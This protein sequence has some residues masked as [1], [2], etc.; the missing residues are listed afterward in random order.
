MEKYQRGVEGVVGAALVARELKTDQQMG[1]VP[2]V[3]ALMEFMWG[4]N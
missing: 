1:F 4:H 3:R 2:L